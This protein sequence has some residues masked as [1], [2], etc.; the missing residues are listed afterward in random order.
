MMTQAVK[1]KSAG[2]L[3]VA[4]AILGS[5][6]SLCTAQDGQSALGD[7]KIEGEDIERLV[8]RRNDGHTETLENPDKTVKL[9]EG[10]YL[11]QDVR[12]KGGY[13]RRTVASGRNRV[14]ISEDTTASLTVGAPLK[15]TVSVRRQGSIL[16]LSYGLSGVD[17]N[18]YAST[19]VGSRNRPPTFTIYKGDRKIATG[20]FEFG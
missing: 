16:Q 19:I 20:E 6:V 13:A 4:L 12:L 7:L 8:L 18:T 5:G 1:L 14:T 9:P 2:L 15:Q 11:L 10:Q 17:G 3:A